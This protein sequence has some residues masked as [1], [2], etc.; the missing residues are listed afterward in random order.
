VGPKYV[1][2]FK[3][4]DMTTF[5]V[6]GN[7]GALQSDPNTQADF[8]NY[9]QG[10][11]KD[12]SPITKGGTGLGFSTEITHFM[13]DGDAANCGYWTEC[14]TD[15]AGSSSALGDRRITLSTGPFT[16]N[17]GDA[18]QIVFG[19]VGPRAPIASTP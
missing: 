16:I 3:N 17:P 15:N 5:L 11:W 2:D 19:I 8:Y 18:Q 13:Y 7:G 10:K 4:L 9:M 12:G 6:Y 14:N 1:D